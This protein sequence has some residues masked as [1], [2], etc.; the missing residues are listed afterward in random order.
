MPEPIDV[1]FL[2][3]V[4]LYRDGFATLPGDGRDD[5][6]RSFFARRIIDDDRRARRAE[7]RGDGGPDPFGRAGDDGDFA[8]EFL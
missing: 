3:D 4:R 1:G 6:I 7:M 2:R 8:S 5:S